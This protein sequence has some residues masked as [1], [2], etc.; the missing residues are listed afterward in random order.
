M[1]EALRGPSET[2]HDGNL[3]VWVCLV[4]APLRIQGINLEW[5]NHSFCRARFSSPSI[6]PGA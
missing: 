6:G 5:P 2:V 3:I 1:L 4:I